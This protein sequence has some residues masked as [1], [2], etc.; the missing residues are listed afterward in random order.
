MLLRKHI[1]VWASKG[2]C[3]MMRV[4]KT[5][6]P[7]VFLDQWFAPFDCFVR[8]YLKNG[9]QSVPQ[10]DGRWQQKDPAIRRPRETPQRLIRSQTDS[11][12]APHLIGVGGSIL[13]DRN[14]SVTLSVSVMKFI[15]FFPSAEQDR[16]PHR[17]AKSTAL[18]LGFCRRENGRTDK[19]ISLVAGLI[20]KLRS[21]S[22]SCMLSSDNGCMTRAAVAT[23][24][25]E[26]HSHVSRWIR[27]RFPN[28]FGL[29]LGVIR[30]ESR[31]DLNNVSR[32]TLRPT[33]Y[34]NPT[35]LALDTSARVN[36][37]EGYK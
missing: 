11:T 18:A 32:L 12:A 35:S 14:H 24:S 33:T 17:D 27:M 37:I 36:I 20:S 22:R 26:S 25:R 10:Q 5:M 19:S 13:R 23:R 6:N 34:R 4:A 2:R 21:W 3:G 9:I 7:Q 1:A 15:P 16:I 29:Q 28:F 8:V 30:T 31:D